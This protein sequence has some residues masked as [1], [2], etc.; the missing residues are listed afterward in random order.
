MNPDRDIN[1]I[2]KILSYC[3]QID[4]AHEEFSQYYKSKDYRPKCNKPQAA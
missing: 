3:N 2:E 4:E 1:I